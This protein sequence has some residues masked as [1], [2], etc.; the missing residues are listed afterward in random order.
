MSLCIW[1]KTLGVRYE[2]KKIVEQKSCVHDKLTV[3]SR[4]FIYVTNFR[5]VFYISR[6][7]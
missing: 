7:I 5:S 6:E 4:D 2:Q 1:C 3:R